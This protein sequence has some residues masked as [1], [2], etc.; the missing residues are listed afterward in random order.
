[1]MESKTDGFQTQRLVFVI[2]HEI[3]IFQASF[4]KNTM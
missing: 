1:M 3:V 4:D 2:E